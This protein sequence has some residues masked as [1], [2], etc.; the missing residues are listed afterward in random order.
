MTD[1]VDKATR[2]RMMAG[3]R[4]KDTKPE[5]FLR[6]E[7]HALGFRFRLHAKDIAG[8]PDIVFPKYHALIMVHGCFW[9][10]HNCRCFK[11]P[12]TNMEFWQKK[13]GENQTRDRK[14]SIAQLEAGWRYLII[15]E[16]AVRG[17]LKDS[18]NKNVVNLA[19]KWLVDNQPCAE[20]NESGLTYLNR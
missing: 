4:G 12:S 17:H 16:C 20:I 8:K 1:V 3:I 19:A 11:F 7:L 10:G 13:I 9:H 2:S 6:K 14:H 18:Q 5:I 15:W